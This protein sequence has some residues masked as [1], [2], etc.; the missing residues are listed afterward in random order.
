[1]YSK[2]LVAAEKEEI[3]SW[4]L[5]VNLDKINKQNVDNAAPDDMGEYDFKIKIGKSTKEFHVY[6]VKIDEVFNLVQQINRFLP[7][8]YRI[9]Y[10]D[11][12]FRFKK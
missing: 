8:Q 11:E 4:L 12:Y 2:G 10:D 1:M 3:Q 6:Q 7:D 5:K 9:G